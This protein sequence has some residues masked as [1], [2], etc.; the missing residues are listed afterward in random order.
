MGRAAGTSARCAADHDRGHFGPSLSER[1][2]KPPVFGRFYG[3]PSW[4]PAWNI[5]TVRIVGGEPMRGYQMTSAI[6]RVAG[7]GGLGALIF[8][9]GCGGS[10]FG[11][12]PALAQE[13][14]AQPG[15]PVVVTCEPNQRTLVRQALVN[16][17]A[18]SQVEC[19]SQGQGYVS[20]E[21]TAI[22]QP[23]PTEVR[24]RPVSSRAVQP[25][26]AA[27]NNGDLADTRVIP[28]NSSPSPTAAR[29]V[30]AQ[31]V[32]YDDRPVRRA[33]VRTKTKSAVIIGSSAGA[34]AGV[35]AAVGG[36]KGA[37][38]GAVLGG[39]GATLWDQLT[40]RRN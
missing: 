3:Q 22:A 12:R 9:Y 26:A 40:R 10:Q 28:V 27:Q 30:R 18:V 20:A 16:G 39:G 2:K 14:A 37:L 34:G 23:L 38:I 25:V 8:S 24:Y 33:P 15:A 4:H 13:A 29:P 7:L 19:V 31:Q 35:G 36:K 6:G 5:P 17:A 1:S 32:V 21:P 11:M